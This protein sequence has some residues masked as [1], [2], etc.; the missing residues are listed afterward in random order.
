MT[1]TTTN[2]DE[3]YSLADDDYEYQIKLVMAMKPSK[4][5]NY[6]DRYV[7]EDGVITKI[8]FQNNKL[9]KYDPNVKKFVELIPYSKYV[10]GKK[11]KTPADKFM[12][13][14]L[15]EKGGDY[16]EA[17]R[18]QQHYHHTGNSSGKA[19]KVIATKNKITLIKK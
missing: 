3:C 14:I 18:A 6:K 17:V 15:M 8:R 13:K 12:E 1:M 16:F 7:G 11:N 2:F 9:V 19:R 5:K 10:S 4:R